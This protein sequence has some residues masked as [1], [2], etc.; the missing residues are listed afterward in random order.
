METRSSLSY[1]LIG[2]KIVYL[3]II[4]SPCLV[5]ICDGDKIP[6]AMFFNGD[7]IGNLKI[8]LSP[9]LVNIF[10]EDKISIVIFSEWGQDRKFENHLVPIQSTKKI[11]LME[12]WSPLSCF[13]IRTRCPPTFYILTWGHDPHLFIYL[14]ERY[15]PCIL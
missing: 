13:W 8:I 6:I 12:T 10:D 9:C 15:C 3:K 11:F 7:K 1:Y 2:D 4:L 5:N 14:I